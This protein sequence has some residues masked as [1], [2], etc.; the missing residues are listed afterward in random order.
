MGI[1]E[2]MK[3]ELRC[4]LSGVPI[5]KIKNLVK[6]LRASQRGGEDG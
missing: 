5:V 1:R 6:K 2:Q 4:K 3:R